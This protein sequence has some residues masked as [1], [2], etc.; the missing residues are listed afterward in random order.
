MNIFEVD[1]TTMIVV[2]GIIAL[3]VALVVWQIVGGVR[4][5]KLG[6]ALL[7]AHPESARVYTRLGTSMS[8][9]LKEAV[10]AMATVNVSAVDNAQCGFVLDASGGFTPV[11]PGNHTLKLMATIQYPGVAKRIITGQIS[12]ALAPYQCALV[13]YDKAQQAFAVRDLGYLTPPTGSVT[14]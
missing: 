4:R 1:S 8:G 12:V 10:G 13:G 5:K 7:A 2:G 14:A 3:I 9:V 6:V 11:S